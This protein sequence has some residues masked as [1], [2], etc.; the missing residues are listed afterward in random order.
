MENFKN[1]LN[2]EEIE[3]LTR[4]MTFSCSSFFYL[5]G[6]LKPLKF[7]YMKNNHASIA[8]GIEP[9]NSTPIICVRAA[10]EVL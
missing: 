3:D 6:I 1:L 9:G 10:M 2:S 5:K 4:G 8:Q 7:L